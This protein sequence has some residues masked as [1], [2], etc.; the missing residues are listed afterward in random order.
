MQRYSINIDSTTISPTPNGDGTWDHGNRWLIEED[1]DE[2]LFA[3]PRSHEEHSYKVVSCFGYTPEQIQEIETAKLRC[4]L[5]EGADNPDWDWIDGIQSRATRGFAKSHWDLQ[6]M[7]RLPSC[8]TYTPIRWVEAEGRHWPEPL[9]HFKPNGVPNPLA[10]EQVPLVYE[11]FGYYIDYKDHNR[12]RGPKGA[13]QFWQKS[14]TANE[15]LYRYIKS[16]PK[17]KGLFRVCRIES[18]LHA[19]HVT[20][21]MLKGAYCSVLYSTAQTTAPVHDAGDQLVDHA[22][23]DEF[24]Q[25]DYEGSVHDQRCW[26]DRKFFNH[27]QVYK[28]ALA[29]ELAQ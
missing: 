7:E 16:N 1:E 27:E 26:Q 23:F 24:M 15:Y 17:S 2:L 10:V 4:S 22:E 14:Q 25:W 11:V 3:V 29:R 5:L 28:E 8:H 19:N 9:D 12:S 21:A 6:D 18:W 13:K 20:E